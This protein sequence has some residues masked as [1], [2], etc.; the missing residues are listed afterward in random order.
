[1]RYRSIEN[2]LAELD[3]LESIG[4]K[5][6]SI[7]DD[8]FNINKR[9]AKRILLEIAKRKYPF[10]IQLAN[11]I[12]ADF[13]D[14]LFAKLAYAAGVYKTAFGVE[15]GS[16]VVVNFLKKRLDL[17]VLPKSIDILHKHTISDWI[18]H[19]WFT[20]RK[21]EQFGPHG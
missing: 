16:Q 3:Y 6:I 2:V 8:V 10:K 14:E 20:D 1:M 17:K 19:L 11:G 12:R 4:A 15:S 5:E 18:F 13:V 9:R 21:Y 7:E